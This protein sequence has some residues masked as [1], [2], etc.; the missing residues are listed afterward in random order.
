VSDDKNDLT[1]RAELLR[2]A[3]RLVTGDRNN[4]YGPPHQDF[5]HTADMLTALGFTQNGEPVQAHH[6]AMI[7]MCV[8]LSRLSW[9]PDKEDSWVDLGGYA[10]CGWEARVLTRPNPE[11]INEPPEFQVTVDEKGQ[12][13][14]TRPLWRGTYADPEPPKSV[15]LL[16][17]LGEPET[18]ST[19]F[20]ERRGDKWA[21]T[22]TPE[23]EGNGWRWDQALI[24]E[25]AFEEV[26]DA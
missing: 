2:E 1:L 14:M 9:S 23:G 12:G 22:T 7:L 20:I 24:K 6:V 11:P 18:S 17:L 15:T 19:R 8:K 16:R 21:W 4:S 25:Y 26:R 13:R 10:A 3:E 5:Q